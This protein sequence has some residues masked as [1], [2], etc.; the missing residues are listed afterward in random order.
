MAEHPLVRPVERLEQPA[1]LVRREPLRIDRHLDL[2]G[3]ADVP[4]VRAVPEG[5]ALDRDAVLVDPR[6]QQG[7][8]RPLLPGECG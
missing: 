6:E 3:L 5:D 2:V 7:F 1:L 8:E 4:H